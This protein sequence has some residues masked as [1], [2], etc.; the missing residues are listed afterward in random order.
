MKR[1]KIKILIAVAV[2]ITLFCVFFVIS[3]KTFEE[4][5]PP[6]TSPKETS[7]KISEPDNSLKTVLEVEKERY[8]SKIVGVI[9]VYE[10]MQKLKEEEKINFKEKTYSGMGKFIEE[11]NNI[12]NNGER[13]WIYYV[14]GEK[15]TIGV[16]NYKIKNGDTVSWKY[17][18]YTN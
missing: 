15:A 11:I 6:L 1:E 5:S 8:E 13:N 9:S 14:N 10:F 12:K 17:E 16:S 3:H 2:S 7:E 4:I 18:K